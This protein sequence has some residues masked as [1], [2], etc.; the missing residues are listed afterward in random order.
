[1]IYDIYIIVFQTCLLPTIQI[2]FDLPIGLQ[3][4]NQTVCGGIVRCDR[5]IVGQLRF[6]G[7]GQLLAQLD[8]PLVERVD[9]PDDA[10][11]EDLVLVEGY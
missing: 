11:R 4:V 5:F 7:F 6:N 10:L 1:M 2:H 3:E 8:A 9:V